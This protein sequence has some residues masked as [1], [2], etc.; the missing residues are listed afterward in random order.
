[1]IAAAAYRL[2][3]V[4]S[5]F[6][7]IALLLLAHFPACAK[8]IQPQLFI[9]KAT[10]EETMIASKKKFVIWRDSL[11]KANGSSFEQQY[12][13]AVAKLFQ[14]VLDS[15]ADLPP[16]EMVR[17]LGGWGSSLVHTH[18][19]FLEEDMYKKERFLL[20][21]ASKNLVALYPEL[22]TKNPTV[23]IFIDTITA[24]PTFAGSSIRLRVYSNIIRASTMLRERRQAL[25]QL[26]AAEKFYKQARR[27]SVTIPALKKYGESLKL[28][29]QFNQERLIIRESFA[30]I[31]RAIGAL[32]PLKSEPRQ[33]SF[34]GLV[35]SAVRYKIRSLGIEEIVFTTRSTATGYLH[36]YENFAYSGEEP[37]KALYGVGGRLIK[38][39]IKS[40]LTRD[41][42]TDIKGAIRDPQI[43]YSGKKMV[44]SYRKGGNDN[45]HLYELNT[46]GTNL[47][48][49]THSAYNDIEPTYTPDDSIIFSSTRGKR[50]VPCFPA[51]AAILHKC[52]SN[53]N[54]V[55]PLSANVETEC[56]PW[57]LPD[58]RV[59]FMRWEYVDRTHFQFHQL[60]TINPDGTGQMTYFGNMVL[61]DGSTLLDAKP[62][63]GSNKVIAV[64]SHGHG[65][66]EHAGPV[67]IVDASNGPDDLTKQRYITPKDK[68][69]YVYR[70]PY[71]LSRD[72]FLVAREGHILLLDS[73]G[74]QAPLFTLTEMSG[75]DLT[76]NHYWVHEPR[77]IVARPRERVIPSRTNYS[78]KNAVM[79]L[80][81]VHLGRNMS[82][83]KPGTIKKL[84]VLEVLPKPTHQNG[85]TEPLSYDA[86][87][88]LERILGTVPVEPDGSAYFEVPPMRSLFFVAL[89]EKNISVKRMHSF[90]SA[91]PGEVSACIGCHENRTMVLPRSS[92]QLA[93]R[94]PPASITP[95]SHVPQIFDYSRDIQPIWDRHCVSCHNNTLRKGD[96]V[97]SADYGSW[98][99]ASYV[100][101]IA[102][103]LISPSSGFTSS[104]DFK[105]NS[106]PRTVGTSASR[107][108]EL[109]QPRHH[110]VSLSDQELDMVRYWIESGGLYAGTYAAMNTLTRWRYPADEQV[111]NKK[112]SS[113]H[114]DKLKTGIWGGPKRADF[115]ERF[116]LRVNFTHLDSSLLLLAPLAKKDGGLGLCKNADGSEAAIYSSKNDVEYLAMRQALLRS[117]EEFLPQRYENKGWVPTVHYERE[118][119]RYGVLAPETDRT[120]GTINVYKT[121]EAYFEQFWHNPQNY[122]NVQEYLKQLH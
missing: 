53:G 86:T 24:E 30:R 35:N 32:E 100:T 1:M 91:M 103:K 31:Y 79:V 54:N 4:H 61:D 88:M 6:C 122:K 9:K 74:N 107:L 64:N 110:G 48:Q 82:G 92:H 58:G 46:D 33:E 104:V 26:D 72:C 36:F 62:I 44:I 112:C 60:W 119:K 69:E 21:K 114:T 117:Q 109:V 84:L 57:M 68:N 23:M 41:I 3:I 99:R 77:P 80:S 7:C 106:A 19:W 81:D 95:L 43:H 39:D 108:M 18:A 40:G 50:W 85:H 8:G 5:F 89:D 121:D 55:R 94:K 20:D 29:E 111:I 65:R 11:Q 75:I 93:L 96:V 71:P 22:N 42:V 63:P 98:F 13:D 120:S 14:S 47:R 115:N 59:L 101:L 17:D 113:C 70:D 66:N 49:L 38:M 56:T 27:E 15:F 116:G 16:R 10:F 78:K 83:I 45:Y 67:V 51:Q 97:M 12:T 76:R 34:V 118:M 25:E 90:V 37:D 2:A 52:D 87:F 105:G 73:S 102:R 28:E